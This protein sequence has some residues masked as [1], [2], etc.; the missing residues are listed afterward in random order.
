MSDP[1]RANSADVQRKTIAILLHEKDARFFSTKYLARLLMHEWQKM[2]FVVELIR[3]TS[4][5]IPA[6]VLIPHLDTTVTPSAYRTFIDLYPCA[7]NRHVFDVSK[8]RLSVNLLGREDRYSGPVI[9]K[10]DR[11]FGGLPEVIL[12]QP[13]G[14]SVAARLAGEIV[15]RLPRRLTRHVGWKHVACLPTDR[16]PVFPSLQE[17]PSAVFNNKNLVVERFLPEIQGSEYCVRYCYFFGDHSVNI[18]VKS[19]TRL[20]KAENASH[21]EEAPIPPELHSLRR[22]LALDYGKV[23][24]VLRDGQVVLFDVNR[25]PAYTLLERGRL[26]D[27]AARDLARGISSLALRSQ[28]IVT[29]RAR[30]PSSV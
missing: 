9:V 15:P 17:V 29:S 8:S 25:T 3:G 28:R 27:R 13:F 2:G 5:V 10:T 26:A 11:N 30:P 1:E 7:V 18:L 20:V 21:V 19:K 23:D 16:Y 24:Y 22:D 6:D 4:K 12:S 14:R